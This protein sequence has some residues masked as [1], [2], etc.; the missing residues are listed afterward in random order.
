MKF[1]CNFFY[2]YYRKFMKDNFG[3]F[4]NNEKLKNL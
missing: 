3:G 1:L 4:Y 2:L